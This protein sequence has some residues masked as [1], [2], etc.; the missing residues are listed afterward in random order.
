MTKRQALPPTAARIMYTVRLSGIILNTGFCVYMFWYTVEQC[1]FLYKL[2][3]RKVQLESVVEESV[4]NFL[5]TQ[6]QEQEASI[7]LLT[8]S[9]PLNHFWARNPVENTMYIL[10]KN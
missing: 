7:N 4:I 8:K 1:V 5:R 2:C 6:F 10:K 3:E 9:G